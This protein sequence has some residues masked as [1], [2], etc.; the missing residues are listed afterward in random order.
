MRIFEIIMR[1]LIVKE[2]FHKKRVSTI[3]KNS[4][5]NTIIRLNIR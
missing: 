1:I 4:K 5:N 3:I 2:A